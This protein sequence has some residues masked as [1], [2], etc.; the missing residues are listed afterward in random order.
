LDLPSPL[1]SLFLLSSFLGQF[2]QISFF[3]FH[4][5]KQ[6]TSTMYTLIPPFLVPTLFPLAPT[7][8]K[9][10]FFPPALHFFLMYIDSLKEFLLGS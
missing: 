1:F 10:L 4:G 7:P 2:Q 9:D 6:N 8:G 5:W 3:Y